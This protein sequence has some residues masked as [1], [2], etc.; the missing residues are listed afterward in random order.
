MKPSTRHLINIAKFGRTYRSSDP[1]QAKQW[2]SKRLD[3]SKSTQRRAK[4]RRKAY[5]AHLKSAYRSSEGG[6]KMFRQQ[7]INNHA[8]LV[9]PPKGY[10]RSLLAPGLGL[11]ALR[12][13]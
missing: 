7:R 9:K 2:M 10:Q 11:L 13:S 1:Y 4:A 8:S 3:A 12:R 6:S 5:A